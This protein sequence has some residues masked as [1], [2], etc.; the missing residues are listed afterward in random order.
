MRRLA[1]LA[2][3]LVAGPSGVQAQTTPYFSGATWQHKT[4]AEAGINA[5]LLKEAVDFAVAGESRSSRDLTMN[6]YQS[7]GR[8]PIGYDGGTTGGVVRRLLAALK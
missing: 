7:F 6:H 8:E 5:A 2:L 3:L 4:P 1:L